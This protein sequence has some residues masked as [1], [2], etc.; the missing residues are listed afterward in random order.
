M[1]RKLMRFYERTDGIPTRWIEMVRH[2]LATLR[3]QVQASRMV[4]DYV[5]DGV[6]APS[7][8][9]LP[10]NLALDNQGNLFIAE[11]PGGSAP[12]KT[13]GDDVWMAPFNA[14]NPDQAGQAVRFL[15]IEG[16]GVSAGNGERR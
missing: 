8:F 5:R 6:N 11:D 7:D 4:T 9:D 16:I 10:D 3:P 15:S 1:G 2:T 12:T 13:L 14:G